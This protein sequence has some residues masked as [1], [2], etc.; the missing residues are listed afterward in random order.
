MR[1]AQD[2]GVQ[3]ARE[4]DVVG[5]EAAAVGLGGSVDLGKPVADA[6]GT[7]SFTACATESLAA[8]R[9][10]ATGARE[11]GPRIPAATWTA[12]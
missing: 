5:V 12:S 11:A 10:D 6:H 7:I 4:R 8:A 3:H 1:R 2:L 9:S